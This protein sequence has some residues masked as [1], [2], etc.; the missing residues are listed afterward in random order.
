MQR[1][2]NK[3]ED[4]GDRGPQKSVEILLEC[5]E[6]LLRIVILKLNIE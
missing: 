3:K 5:E 1:P 6:V 2:R 4:V